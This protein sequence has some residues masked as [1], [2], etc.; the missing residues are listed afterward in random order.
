LFVKDILS[1]YVVSKY[2]AIKGGEVSAA[3]MNT[4]L[5]VGGGASSHWDGASGYVIFAS[6][7]TITCSQGSNAHLKGFGRDFQNRHAK[8]EAFL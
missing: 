2:R 7:Q 3:L 4:R 8:K 1:Q 5:Q 6:P